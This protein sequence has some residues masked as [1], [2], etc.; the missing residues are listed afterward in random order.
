V[1]I[2]VIAVGDFIV[3]QLLIHWSLGARPNHVNLNFGA[4]HR[5]AHREKR[6]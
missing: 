2:S 6:E 4:K 3:M 1:T 5:S